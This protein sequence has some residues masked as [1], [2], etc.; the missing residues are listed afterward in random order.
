MDD[1]PK[2]RNFFF[3]IEAAFSCAIVLIL[4]LT[5]PKTLK[6]VLLQYY[7]SGFAAF[8][9]TNDGIQPFWKYL[10]LRF[11][12]VVRVFIGFRL[13]RCWERSKQR[14]PEQHVQLIGT[15][16]VGGERR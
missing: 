14:L 11:E 7:L 4:F 12:G 6:S 5:V 13:S 16:R 10:M 2:L 8:C 9:P 15:T 3:S 1:S